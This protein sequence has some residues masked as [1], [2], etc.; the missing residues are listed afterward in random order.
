MKIDYI[1]HSG[2]LVECDGC[3]LLFDYF[4]GE[5]PKLNKEKPIIVFSSHAHK[6]HY[7]PNVFALLK[8]AKMDVLAVLAKDIRKEKYPEGVEVLRAC[9]SSLYELPY[10]I[11][12]ETLTSTDAGVAYFVTTPEGTVF[13]AGDL[14]DWTWD[15]E[16]EEENRQMRGSYRAEINKLKGRHIDA[17]FIPLDHRQEAHYADGMLYFLRTA[18]VDTVYPMHM[19]DRCDTADRF[20]E[21]YPEYKGKIIFVK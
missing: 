6:D 9:A 8:N 18:S 11:T 4:K 12:V 1:Y 15:G 2:F 7:E 17:A 21:E 13:H 14:N 10:G 16:P 3:Y 19:W 5:L 20:V